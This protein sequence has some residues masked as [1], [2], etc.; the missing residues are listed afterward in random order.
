M[1]IVQATSLTHYVD[2]ALIARLFARFRGRYGNLWTSRATCD[3]DWEFIIDDWLQE[4]SKFTL[5]QVRAAVNKALAIYKEFPPTLGQLVDLCMKESGV[6][7]IQE[8]IRLMLIRDFNHPLVKMIYDKIGSWI[9]TNG[10]EDDIQRKTK[11]YYIE[12]FANFK[13][14]PQKAWL[15]LESFN[16]KPKELPPPDKIPTKQEIKSFKERLSQYQQNLEN[17]K[18]LHA[19]IP[20][21]E[22]PEDKIK[23]GA[24]SFDQKVYDEWRDYLLSI[25]EEQTITLPIKYI[26]ERNRFLNMNEQK[27]YLEELG[28]NNKL[29]IKNYGKGCRE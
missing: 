24:R 3:E 7:G 9:L 16:Q 23:V 4:L 6:P 19:G 13:I 21:K 10:K 11:E 5:D 27:K 8:V 29:S 12:E 18:L 17:A 20:Y 22:F 14:N 2:E 25:P 28:Y 26:Y 15:E 1:T